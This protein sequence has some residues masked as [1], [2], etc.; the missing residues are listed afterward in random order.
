MGVVFSP[1][2]PINTGFF[3]YTLATHFFEY[4]S[5]KGPFSTKFNLRQW[6]TDNS[7][8]DTEGIKRVNAGIW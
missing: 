4:K 8:S 3:N 1:K 2:T 7:S 6:I 5:D